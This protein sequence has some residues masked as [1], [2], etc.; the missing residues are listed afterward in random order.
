[1]VGVREFR[2]LRNVQNSSAWHR[3]PCSVG[4]GVQRRVLELTTHLHLVTNEEWVEQYRHACLHRHNFT[5]FYKTDPKWRRICFLFG[6]IW[7]VICSCPGWGV[8]LREVGQPVAENCEVVFQVSSEP[9][10][11]TWLPH[12]CVL[13]ILIGHVTCVEEKTRTHTGLW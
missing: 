6:T 5:L 9:L 3:D 10:P 12:Y 11:Y 13:N 2:L 1:M 7:T 4:T 8:L